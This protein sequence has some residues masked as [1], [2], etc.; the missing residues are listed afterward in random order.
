MVEVIEEGLRDMNS[1]LGTEV[2]ISSKGTK[3]FEAL[4]DIETDHLELSEERLK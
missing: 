4:I 2:N 1:L 3:F